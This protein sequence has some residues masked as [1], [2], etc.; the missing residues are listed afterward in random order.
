M[1]NPLS[2]VRDWTHILMDSSWVLNLLS[3]HGK[4][5]NQSL[6]ASFTSQLATWL[7]ENVWSLWLRTQRNNHLNRNVSPLC[8]ISKADTTWGINYTSIKKKESSPSWNQ[9]FKYKENILS[10]WEWSRPRSRPGVNWPV[11]AF[12]GVIF[13]QLWQKPIVG[14][15]WWQVQVADEWLAS[16]S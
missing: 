9:T 13:A 8:C 14:A 3:H 6:A 7:V 16:C 1:L 11:S 15:L 10:Q 12:P 2:K 5:G 4:S